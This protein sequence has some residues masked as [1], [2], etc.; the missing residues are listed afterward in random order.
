MTPEQHAKRI[1]A[2]STCSLPIVFLRT[3]EGKA[4][5]TDASSVAPEDDLYIH[6][7]HVS[8]FSTCPAAAKHRKPR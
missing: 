8:H 5:P 1:K 7:K 3:R 6:G 2:C 4:M